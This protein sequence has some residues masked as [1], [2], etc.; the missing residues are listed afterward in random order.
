MGTSSDRL[1]DRDHTYATEQAEAGKHTLLSIL[2]IAISL[3]LPGFHKG[4]LLCLNCSYPCSSGERL[5][6]SHP[7]SLRDPCPDSPPI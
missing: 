1:A 3:G 7:S 5:M 4:H 6:P 2:F